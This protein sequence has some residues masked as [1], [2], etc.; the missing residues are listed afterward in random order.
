MYK[1]LNIR[2]SG[3]LVTDLKKAL[4]FYK[5]L[6]QMEEVSRGKLDPRRSYILLDI[7]LPLT[8]VKLKLP[9]SDMLIELY[10]FE[11]DTENHI[12]EMLLTKSFNHI[13]FTVK[14]AEYLKSMLLVNGVECTSNPE[15]DKEKKHKLFFARDFDGNLLEFVEV[16]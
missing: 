14:N 5:E 7:R 16:V 9:G 1:V 10:F 8:W 15:F 2:H 3:I 6:L 4:Y 11:N 13:S 12:K